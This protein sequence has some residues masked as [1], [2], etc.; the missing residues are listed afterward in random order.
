MD[1]Y[2]HIISLIINQSIADSEFGIPESQGPIR[3]KAQHMDTVSVQAFYQGDSNA[4][5]H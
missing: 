5:V 3:S 1:S 4:K 2:E